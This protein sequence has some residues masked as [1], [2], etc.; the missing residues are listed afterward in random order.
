MLRMKR[1]EH[2]AAAS[3][4]MSASKEENDPLRRVAPVKH[5]P[6]FANVGQGDR[7]EIVSAARE[8]KFSRCRPIFPEGE[9][10]RTVVLLTAGLAKVVLFGQDGSEVILRLVGPGEV[11]GLTE[12]RSKGRHSLLA[13]AQCDS[14][15]LVWEADVFEVFVDR[16]PQLRR[17][18]MNSVS[19]Q[20]WELEER[21]REISMEKVAVRL[22]R[23]LVRLFNQV[24]RRVNGRIEINFSCEELAQLTGTTSFTVS[25]LLTDWDQRGVVKTRQDSVSV[26]NNQGLYGL[27]ESH[28]KS[29]DGIGNSIMKGQAAQQTGKEG[30]RGWTHLEPMNRPSLKAKRKNH[31][32]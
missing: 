23:Q 12:F 20:L 28:S 27:A 24:G 6:L 3:A 18:V 7:Q 30:S 8:I 2:H 25:R 14:T 13:Q 9:A 32:T 15:A 26:H 22:T 19:Q 4:W 21:Y 31:S 17:N 10:V 11:V 5:S 16:F 1:S 29:D